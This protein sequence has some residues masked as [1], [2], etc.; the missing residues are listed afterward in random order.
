MVAL[1]EECAVTLPPVLTLATVDADDV[2]LTTL[3]ITWVLPS[4]NVPVAT[5]F[6]EVAGVSRAA[7][8]VTEIEAI[9]AELTWSGAEFETK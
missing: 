5:Q 1:P 6:T 2:Q 3:V 4:L 9:V 8:G 7:T